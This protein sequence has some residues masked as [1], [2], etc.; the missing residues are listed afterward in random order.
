MASQL[1]KPLGA[2]PMWTRSLEG[3]FE[4][5]RGD[6]RIGIQRLPDLR[7]SVRI[8]TRTGA[9]VVEV[10]PAGI[11][12]DGVAV[13][14]GDVIDDLV[15]EFYGD[16][17]GQPVPRVSLFRDHLAGSFV[18]SKCAFRPAAINF[19]TPSAAAMRAHLDD[20]ERQGHNVASAGKW[21]VREEGRGR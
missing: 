17:F 21:L 7:N 8:S 4:L 15:I 20:H 5:S 13:G 14:F 9:F 3:S 1:K 19:E 6:Q 12:R 10:S 16:A 2:T 18:C 11:R